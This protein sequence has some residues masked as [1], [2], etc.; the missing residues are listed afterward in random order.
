MKLLDADIVL[1][2][3]D[4]ADALQFHACL[5][6]VGFIGIFR[7]FT[8]GEDFLEFLDSQKEPSFFSLFLDLVLPGMSGFDLLE[9]IRRIDPLGEV[10]RTF[11]ISSSTDPVNFQRA[12]ALGVSGYFL[13]PLASS[14]IFK[15]RPF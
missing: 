14:A 10:I 13:K 5:Q 3:D 15:I 8:D 11:I 4:V 6:E 12:Q 7:H 1:I 9:A 2:E